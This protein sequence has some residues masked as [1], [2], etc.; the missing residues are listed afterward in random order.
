MI[1][2][3]I[4]ANY[5]QAYSTITSCKATLNRAQEALNITDLDVIAQWR[6]EELRYLT[7]TQENKEPDEMRIKI[8]YVETL[9]KL[10]SAECISSLLFQD[11]AD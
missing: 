7:T 10:H 3:F 1:A 5:R 2:K 6:E 8:E 9:K 11:C 4:I